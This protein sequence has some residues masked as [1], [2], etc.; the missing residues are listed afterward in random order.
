VDAYAVDYTA[1]EPDGNAIMP[2]EYTFYGHARIFGRD[3]AM[4]VF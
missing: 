2:S 1:N 3:G 4:Q